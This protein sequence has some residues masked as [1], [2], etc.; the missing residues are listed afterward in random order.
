MRHH[1]V[2][3]DGAS[4]KNLRHRRVLG[5]ALR[6]HGIN[7]PGTDVKLAHAGCMPSTGE[8]SD[9]H[10][11]HAVI[12]S[13]PAVKV[14]LVG[15]ILALLAACGGAQ[16]GKA[17]SDST[18]TVLAASS[19]ASALTTVA[20]SF[21]AS[22]DG[23]E[24]RLSFGGSPTIASQI[25]NGLPA[26]VLITASQ[27]SMALAGTRAVD[28]QVFARN[29]IIIAVAAETQRSIR[30]AVD[31][32]RPNVTWVR[33]DDAVPCGK[34]ALQALANSAVTATPASLEPDVAAVVGRL[35]SGEV[36]AG[37][38][39]RSS[40]VGNPQL[41]A[42]EFPEPVSV[43]LLYSVMRDSE[44]AELARRFVTHLLQAGDVLTRAGF[45]M[46]SP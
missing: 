8:E 3:K 24:V 33:C 1:S 23:V 17:D 21:E 6:P 13:G 40:L 19:M 22:N 28:P 35:L 27:D 15:I 31:L 9:R 42:V 37:I 20:D 32:N 34:A 25:R 10:T 29:W 43:E 11:R 41:F 46:V 44:H 38:V 39:Y 16:E 12:L 30:S 18:L 4:G 5:D 14:T 36:D 26:D 2:D 45:E 7:S